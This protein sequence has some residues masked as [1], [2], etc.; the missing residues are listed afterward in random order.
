MP[1]LSIA[2]K[3]CIPDQQTESCPC[4]TGCA[5]G[6][7]ECFHIISTAQPTAFL[8][9][10][11]ATHY[12]WPP[13]SARLTGASAAS[14]LT[15]SESGN[16][17]HSPAGPLPAGEPDCR[18]CLLPCFEVLHAEE[19][20]QGLLP[21]ELSGGLL[22]PSFHCHGAAASPA[23]PAQWPSSLP[24]DGATQGPRVA[25]A[26]LPSLSPVTIPGSWHGVL[27]PCWPSAGQPVVV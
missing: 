18:W 27:A 6:Q 13:R 17:S 16:S 12:I 21:Q 4:A 26:P 8:P 15:S 20:R 19:E 9:P 3:T 11:V 23:R 2:S 22:H 24:G 14:I 10:D 25:A 1:S 5:W 7:L